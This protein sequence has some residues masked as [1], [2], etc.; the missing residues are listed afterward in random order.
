MRFVAEPKALAK[1]REKEKSPSPTR[2]I[3]CLLLYCL[4][5]LVFISSL[6]FFLFNFHTLTIYRVF[7]FFPTKLEFYD[8]I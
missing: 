7:E 3:L 1:D 2:S 6:Y 8:D 4:N 5:L